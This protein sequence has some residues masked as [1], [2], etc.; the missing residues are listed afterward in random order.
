M[1]ANDVL[2]RCSQCHSSTEAMTWRSTA[3]HAH[4]F[5]HEAYL[6]AAQEEA[7]VTVS[8]MRALSA[9][10][11]LTICPFILVIQPFA[12]PLIGLVTYTTYFLVP[13][14]HVFHA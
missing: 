9:S 6:S 13:A 1:E 7:I 8:G 3:M 5:E 10:G 14:L 11:C 12:I 2:I 4:R